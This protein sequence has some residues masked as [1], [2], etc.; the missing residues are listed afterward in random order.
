MIYIKQL[1]PQKSFC[2]LC[3]CK[4]RKLNMHVDCS[5][6]YGELM[7]NANVQIT[8]SSLGYGCRFL[9]VFRGY[10]TLKVVSYH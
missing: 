2:V 6:N 7:Q 9:E 5:W 4:I 1:K 3:L 10:N 8:S